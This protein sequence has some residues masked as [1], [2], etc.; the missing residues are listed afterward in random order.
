MKSQAVQ[1]VKNNQSTNQQTKINPHRQIHLHFGKITSK[2]PVKSKVADAI[3]R[4]LPIDCIPYVT[5]LLL[6][7]EDEEDKNG[8]R[9]M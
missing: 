1:H 5:I 2:A 6:V 7:E 3:D 4:H 9:P 8:R